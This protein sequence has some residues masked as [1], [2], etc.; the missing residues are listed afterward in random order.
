M[1][2]KAKT[3]GKKAEKMTKSPEKVGFLIEK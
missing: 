1:K 3:F 2:K